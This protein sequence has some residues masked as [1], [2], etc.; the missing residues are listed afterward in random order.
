MEAGGVG[1][2]PLLCHR[3]ATHLHPV[4][5]K[6][7]WEVRRGLGWTWSFCSSLCRSLVGILE[8]AIHSLNH[9]F[10]HQSV[11]QS[12]NKRFLIISIQGPWR[13]P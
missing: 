12:I 3:T 11:S 9:S 5:G 10:F 13:L 6:A 7:L 2:L 8:L 1:P 4:G